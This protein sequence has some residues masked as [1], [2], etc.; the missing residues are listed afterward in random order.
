MTYLHR[1]GLVV[2]VVM[3]FSAIAS[4][5][6]VTFSVTGPGI[7]VPTGGSATQLDFNFK[8]SYNSP[9]GALAIN[10]NGS[11]AITIFNPDG[12]SP[13]KGTFTITGPGGTFS[14]T[15]AGTLQQPNQSGDTTYSLNYTITG[16]T[17]IFAGATGGGTSVG[18]LNVVTGATTDKLTIT[19]SAPGLTAPV[20]EP[21][22]LLLLGSGLAGLA[23]RLRRRKKLP[24]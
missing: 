10:A 6:T 18:N 14:G 11:V 20:P 12:S 5:D 16:G 24:Q 21:A 17:G 4:A 3:L 13:N 7:S 9:L 23:T 1:L 22:T 15:F 2:L 8:G 19:I